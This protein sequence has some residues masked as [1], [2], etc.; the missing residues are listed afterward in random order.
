MFNY[1]PEALAAAIRGA[2]AGTLHGRMNAFCGVPATLLVQGRPTGE[3]VAFGERILRAFDTRVILNI[4]D[5]LPQN[6]CRARGG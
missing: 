3:I 2:G 6:G 1:E 5:V 4:G